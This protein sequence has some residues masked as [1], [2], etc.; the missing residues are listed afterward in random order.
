MSPHADKPL[1][2]RLFFTRGTFLRTWDEIGI[3][4]RE[5]ALFRALLRRGVRVT[6][7]TCGDARD[8]EY[9]SRLGGIGVRC[10]HWGLPSRY[11]NRFLPLLHAPAFLGRGIVRTNQ[12]DGADLA[13][14]AARFWRKPLIARGGYMY[15]D[16]A[17][18]EYGADSEQARQAFGAEARAFRGARRIVVTTRSMRES[19]A[20]RFPGMARKITVIPN[21]VD[22][23]RFRPDES[24]ERD[25]DRIVYVGRIEDT[26][27]NLRALIDA[28]RKTDLRLDAIGDGPLRGELARQ[29]ADTGRIRFLGKVDHAELPRHLR[30]A[31]FFVLPSRYEGHPKALFE[32]M[33]CAT[34]VLACDVP[35]VREFVES[36]RTAL[37]TAPDG[38]SLQAGI[39]RLAADADL[40]RRIGEAGCRLVRQHYGLDAVVDREID[41]Y[42]EILA[43]ERGTP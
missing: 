39:E 23:D 10:N 9:G 34:P 36:E 3:F 13:I 35:G 14:R 37:L 32:A 40:R 7:V 28:V 16:F 5:V 26:Q 19:I 30:R 29:T 27:K 17:A 43:R 38:E 31:A 25:A 21:Y 22:T 33:A 18:R 8:L 1:H 2:L 15:S 11:Y 42:N 4:D 20:A 41:M 12:F 24:V 6:F